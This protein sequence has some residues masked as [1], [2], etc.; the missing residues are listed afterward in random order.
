MDLFGFLSDSPVCLFPFPDSTCLSFSFPDSPVCL[1][2]CLT[3]LCVFL[4]VCLSACASQVC[5]CDEYLLEKYPLSQYKVNHSGLVSPPICLNMLARL[6]LCLSPCSIS[7]PASRWDVSLTLCWSPRTASTPSC[8]PL[9]LSHLRTGTAP[10]Q[11]PGQEGAFRCA[12]STRSILFCLCL[13]SSRR[14]PQPSP[15][16]G[17][18]DGSPPRSLWAFN[19]LLR[20]RLLC[21]TYVN[22]NIR[23]ID[24]V[25]G[26]GQSL[27]RVPVVIEMVQALFYY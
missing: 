26:L 19:T 13:R 3:H 8:L 21:A 10:P 5:G 11:Q 23:D 1:S 7:A 12:V 20:V 18:G 16:P 6:T 9:A 24:K 15:C 27:F 4:P 2:P 17:G 22:V 14:T 25:C